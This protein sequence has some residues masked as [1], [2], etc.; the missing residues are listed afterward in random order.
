VCSKYQDPK[1]G[2]AVR[3]FLQSAIGPGQDGLTGAGYIPI[4]AEFKPR[5]LNSINAVS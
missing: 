1:V 3:A 4:P 2:T 5:L